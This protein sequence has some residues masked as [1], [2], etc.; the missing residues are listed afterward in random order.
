[1]CKLSENAK[2]RS[3][4]NKLF[5][6]VVDE[7][8][9]LGCFLEIGVV[10]LLLNTEEKIES[11]AASLGMNFRLHLVNRKGHPDFVPNSPPEGLLRAIRQNKLKWGRAV[12]KKVSE[13][14]V[15][16]LIYV[17]NDLDDL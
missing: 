7:V 14:G 3:V 8:E 16:K 10:E 2:R 1:L 15:N 4:V 6:D 11:L 5:T 12:T 9:N 17:C 13:E